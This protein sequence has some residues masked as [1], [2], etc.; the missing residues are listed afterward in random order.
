MPKN[1]F[2]FE[3]SWEVCNKV[4]GIF[5]VIN[6]KI[7]EAVRHFGENYF[8][9][10]PDLKTNPDFEETDEDCWNRIREG[11]AIKEI[12]C[13]FGR[14][15]TPGEPKVILVSP[16]K[17]FNRD[18][19]L[20]EIWEDYG[21]DSI[22]GGWDYVE[23]V[24]FSYASG[25]VIETIYNLI[26]R[27]QEGEAVAHFHEWMCGAGLFCVKK[28]VPEIG[29]VFTTHATILGRTIAGSGMDL[30][31]ALEHISPQR[32][33]SVY[34]ISAKH[35]MEVATAR[36]SDCFTTVS[37]ITATEAKNLL[38]RAPD[39]V[40]PNGLDMDR[41]PDYSIDR[42][43]ALKSRKHLLDFASKFLR[44]EFNDNTRIMIIS[45]RYE[46]YNKGVDIFLHA[47]SKLESEM[48]SGQTVV[49][50]ICVLA[51]HMAINPAAIQSTGAPDPT[52]PL[53]TT[54]RLRNELMDPILGTCN[55]LGL[56]NLPQ[57]KVNVIFVPAYL[58]GHDGIIDMTYYEALS[59]CDLGVFPS[60]YEPWGY[61]PLE[62][63]AHAVPTITTELAGFGRW[64]MTRIGENKGVIIL[65]RQGLSSEIVQKELI[66]ELK[67]FL[68]SSP[69]NL[70]TRRA[71][72]RRIALEANWHEF[73]KCYIEAYDKALHA[74]RS[75][76][77]KLA[78]TEYRERMR[79]TFAG[80]ASVQPHFRTFTAVV[81][82]PSRISRL[83]ELAYNLWWTWNTQAL[84]L[85]IYLDPKLWV[86]TERNPVKM[87]ETVS[88]ERL[89]EASENEG[90]LNL[91][92]KILEEFDSYMNEK[93]NGKNEFY[94]IKWPSPVA[95]FSPE[96]GI[97]ENLPIY[98][99]GLG[100]L[101]GD[102]LKAAS[103]LK[104]PMVG[105][106]LLYR[107]GYFRQRIDKDGWQI[108][109]YPESDF[110]NMPVRMVQDDR[111][112]DVQLAI[113]LPGRTLFANIWE[114][115]VGRVVLYLLD[116]DVS[117]NTVQ[118][119]HITSRLYS[120]D[121]RIRIEQ[122]ILLGMGGVKLLRKIGIK[123]CVY[124]INEGHSAFLL[125]ELI[126]QYVIDEGLSF[127]AAKEIVRGST[128]FTTHTPVEAGNERFSKEVVDYYFSSFFK[129]WGIT[130]PQFWELGRKEMGED[131]PFYMTVLGLK[132]SNCSNAVSKIHGSVARRMWN[133]VWKGF[134]YSD[135]P[136]GYITNG[137]HLQSYIAS[138]LRDM[139]NVYIGPDWQKSFLDPEKW[140]RIH[141]V[142][143]AFLWRIKTSLKFNL[144]NFLVQ[145]VTKQSAKYDSGMMKEELIAK[146]NPAALIIGFA[147]RFAPYKRAYLLFSDLDR[148]ARIVNDERRPVL[149]VFS[150][151]AHPS[152]KMGMDLIKQVIE[153]SKD[154]RFIGK[155]LFIEDYDLY[156]ARHLLQGVD[157]WLN[158]P[159]RP[160]EACGTS[161]QKVIINGGLNM[162]VSDGWWPDGFDGSNGWTVGPVT[163]NYSGFDDSSIADERDAQSL[164]SLLEDKVIP[165]FYDR[166]TNGI[167]KQWTKMVKESMAKLIPK[168]NANR[169]VQQYLEEMYIPSARR[170][171]ALVKNGF[172]L[173][174]EVSDWKN[175]TP[176]R[177]SS[178]KLIDVIFEGIHGDTLQVG[179]PFTVNVRI[180][181]G[182]LEPDEILVELVIGRID[183]HDFIRDPESVPLKLE[184][185]SEKMLTFSCIYQVAQSG[186][187][188]YGI[189][190]LPYNKNLSIKQE[191][192]LALWG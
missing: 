152:D 86:D 192:G 49:V 167:P 46:F 124:H 149:I 73:Y 146:I 161:G 31:T 4:G 22:A 69:E 55:S 90:Y 50:Y 131:K 70:N 33:A 52:T 26:I 191:L 5:T 184:S 134:H 147:R 60:Y 129:R 178:L 99:G 180:D 132:L 100:V 9:I 83:R 172:K 11:V 120:D 63:A 65:K 88:P 27:P 116:T 189:R 53:I 7:S 177:F 84:E 165:M 164:Y 107:N 150:G 185:R 109:D 154:K 187:Y 42:T 159:R 82:L 141:N 155:I 24:M 71:D 148:L 119:R 96:F 190:I 182:S 12:P 44:K 125:L 98:S 16:G 80:T 19:L 144:V 62:S 45:G 21:V 173:A 183:G 39:I 158:T 54:H 170:K 56:K 68:T 28:R 57:N 14:W 108:A 37:E 92:Q 175:K 114:V 13:R 140:K 23:P 137:V 2:L 30:Y 94:P 104:I 121:P 95:Y 111:G 102:L 41:I 157:V 59:G 47:L 89:K 74:A 176:V 156:T 61:T 103:D 40:L 18:Q 35:S 117:R 123:P 91:Y 97:H 142:P 127:E 17:K 115:K 166:D 1:K 138:Q 160:Y 36:E 169:M 29:T 87:L 81:S 34:N 168:F 118:D 79:R 32:E 6:S 110:S 136:I 66:G 3:V 179:E 15:K 112:N 8:L 128:V 72:A 151:K 10:G 174:K 126:N 51:D 48:T 153:I 67:F 133:S 139:L 186:Q 43:D 101:A 135:I 38:G 105:V 113:E 163:E 77:S 20:F 145:S 122:E 75:R 76:M 25:A 181:P 58:N 85:F 106:G 143:D 64:V 188:S 130:S 171:A 93:S 78:T 162:S